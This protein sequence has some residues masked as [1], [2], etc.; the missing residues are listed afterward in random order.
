M[1]CILCGLRILCALCAGQEIPG[2][3]RRAFGLPKCG[4]PVVTERV[5]RPDIGKRHELVA[6]DA[7]AC[8]EN[9]DRGET[10]A[11]A[12][13]ALRRDRLWRADDPIVRAG[14]AEAV[15]IVDPFEHRS[16]V[17]AAF[18]THRSRPCRL[19]EARRVPG[20]DCSADLLTQASHVAQSQSNR[21]IALHGAI[22][23]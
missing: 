11:F 8:H 4:P 1:L 10:S 22:P 14:V 16:V 6:P 7:G 23:V 2:R 5:Q 3:P 21:S 19:A 18:G 12:S 13:L 17:A 9:V 15:S 20:R